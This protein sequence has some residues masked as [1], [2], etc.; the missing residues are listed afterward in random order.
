MGIT[1]RCRAGQGR[2]GKEDGR[3]KTRKMQVMH[4]SS[5]RGD[6]P[7]QGSTGRQPGLLC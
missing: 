2:A 4:V 1:R 5:S 3:K 7:G 6:S